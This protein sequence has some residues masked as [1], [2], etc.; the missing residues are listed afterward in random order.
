MWLFEPNEFLRKKLEIFELIF[1]YDEWARDNC[2]RYYRK[3]SNK[4][5]YSKTLEEET[6]R[7]AMQLLSRA[8]F[9]VRRVNKFVDNCRRQMELKQKSATTTTKSDDV[10][11]SSKLHYLYQHGLNNESKWK[12][13]NDE[14]L[15]KKIL[16]FRNEC[17]CDPLE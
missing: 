13:F 5:N 9:D 7:I 17:G 14:K 1:S 2:Y 4:I 11:Q 6:D 8:C 10:D 15:M 12:Q 3:I 16:E